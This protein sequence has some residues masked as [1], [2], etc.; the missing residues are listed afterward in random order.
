MVRQKAH[1]LGSSSNSGTMALF[2][3]ASLLLTFFVA[4]NAMSVREAERTRAVADSFARRGAAASM[5]LSVVPVGGDMPAVRSVE[6]S[7]TEV[8]PAGA[9]SSLFGEG[10]VLRAQLATDAAFVADTVELTPMAQAKLDAVARLLA[11][12][13]AG[14]DLGLEARVG[15]TPDTDAAGTRLA[16]LRAR[17]LLHRLGGHADG[18]VAAGVYRS[19]SGTIDLELRLTRRSPPSAMQKPGG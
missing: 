7:W 16:A 19:T 13:P 2:A 11:D 8:F 9:A 15:M 12:P 1:N 17:G 6:R 14:L 3:V 5:P 10:R 18:D 4:L